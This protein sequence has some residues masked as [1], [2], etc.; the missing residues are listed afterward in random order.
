[1]T[2]PKQAASIHVEQ[3][4]SELCI[5]NWQ[6]KEVHAL[7]PTAARVWQQCDGQTSLAQIAAILQAELQV[8]DT[9]AK[10][11]AWLTL[12]Q[13]EKAHLLDADVVKPAHRKVLPRRAFLKLGVAAALLPMVHSIVAP[14]PVAAQSPLPT[15]TASPLPLTATASPIPGGTAT[16]SNTPTTTPTS[17][18]TTT[19]TSTP[20][21]LPTETPTTTPTPTMPL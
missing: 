3:L 13:L 5:Y 12:A 17:G 18:P 21:A 15:A 1:M 14:T 7:N 4:G 11:L 16:P 8:P 10:E 19:P 2:Y 6:R 9:E 20:T